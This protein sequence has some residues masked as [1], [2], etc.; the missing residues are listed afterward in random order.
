MNAAGNKKL[1]DF[2]FRPR[3]RITRLEYGLGAGFTV[4]INAAFLTL[5]LTNQVI[6]PALLLVMFVLSIPLTVALFVMAVKRCHDIGL[7]GSFALL[8][9]LPF[10]SLLWLILLAIIPGKD[11]PN[12]YGPAPTFKSD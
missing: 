12:L 9:L 10:I 11:G 5:V 1:L 6:A 2:F 3:G 8:L 4:A 7:A